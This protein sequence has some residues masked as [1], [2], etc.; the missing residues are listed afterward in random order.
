MR[1]SIGTV[2]LLNF[3][4]FFIFLV[5]A[6]LAGA[7][8]YYK[9]FRVNNLMVSAIEKYEGF[10]QLSSAEIDVKVRNLGYEKVDLDCPATKDN[11]N[12]VSLNASGGKKGYDGYCVYLKENDNTR[13]NTD[14]AYFTEQYD[15]YE[16]V[17]IIT[18][19]FPVIQDIVKLRVSAKTDRIYNFEASHDC[20]ING[21]TVQGGS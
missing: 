4:I 14:P 2:S 11:A 6:F 3:V 16:V 15:V 7:M 18:F 5:F 10:N 20:L 8:S 17:T 13:P 19:K 21:C 12:L 9:A 1:E